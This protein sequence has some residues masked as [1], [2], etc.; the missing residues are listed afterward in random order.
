MS[1]TVFPETDT[2]VGLTP[3][4]V[5]TVTVKALAGT[6]TFRSASSKVSARIVPVSVVLCNVGAVAFTV[7]VVQAR[8][9]ERFVGPE[10]AHTLSCR[11]PAGKL[12]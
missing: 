3:A 2:L 7:E 10:L 12:V 8:L 5:P 1:F 4:A 6:A 9:D 11:S